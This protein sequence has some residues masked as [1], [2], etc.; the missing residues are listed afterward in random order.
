[1]ST[2]CTLR[3]DEE[4]LHITPTCQFFVFPLSL[5]PSLSSCYINC[6][7]SSLRLHKTAEPAMGVSHH[8]TC[9]K[10]GGVV[11][12]VEGSGVVANV[13]RMAFLL[14]ARDDLEPLRSF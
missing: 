12:V 4:I 7:D 2:V 5:L 1:M 13:S 3:H 11:H 9:H 14:T 10:G 8:L 6:N